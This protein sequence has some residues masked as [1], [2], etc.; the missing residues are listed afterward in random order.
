MCAARFR[1]WKPAR[2]LAVVFIYVC[3]SLILL[4]IWTIWGD[5]I[6]SQVPDIAREVPRHVARFATQVRASEA[7]HEQ[8][9]F[10]QETR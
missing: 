10:E 5:R 9:T 7:W 6:V 1:G 2:P 8:F 4:P 3:V